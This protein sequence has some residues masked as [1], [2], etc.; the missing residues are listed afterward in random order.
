MDIAKPFLVVVWPD[1]GTCVV[2]TKWLDKSKETVVYPTKTKFPTRLVM[3]L[4]EAQEDWEEC[5][6]E[7]LYSYK[8]FNLARKAAILAAEDKPIDSNIETDYEQP[9]KRQL[10]ARFTQSSDDNN[11]ESENIPTKRKRQAARGFYRE[12]ESV[13]NEE[14]IEK[15]QEV[16]QKYNVPAPPKTIREQLAA[17][18]TQVSHPLKAKI[19]TKNPAN[20][21]NS[22]V[23]DLPHTDLIQCADVNVSKNLFQSPIDE[24]VTSGSEIMQPMTQTSKCFSTQYELELQEK[25]DNIS[26]SNDERSD[27]NMQNFEERRSA[28]YDDRE[29]SVKSDTVKSSLADSDDFSHKKGKRNDGS[30]VIVSQMFENIF[31]V[32]EEMCSKLEHMEVK[33]DRIIKK[34]FPEEIK[35]QRPH[36]IPTFPLRTEED[37]EKQ[38][39]ILADDD[40]LTYVVDVFVTKMKNK[41]SEVA[42]V[43]SVL[44]KIITNS[45]SRAISWGGTQKTKIAFNK[46]KTYDAIQVA[47]L[48][49]FGK[50]RNLKKVEDYVK[51]WF[52]T[53]AQRV[54]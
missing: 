51:R 53:S 37:W 45:L 48:Q 41:E 18:K 15:S 9:R 35:L 4:V 10:P 29:S 33:L 16:C 26:Q 23:I 32:Q 25:Q 12:L 1:G 42:A 7:F 31:K 54:V 21:K 20:I 40:A 38:E 30:T 3:A 39:E 2:A 27:D 17:I 44:P 8:T 28:Q 34:L 49:T 43:Q 47:I 13:E 24:D 52:S 50:T 36:G 46:S 6:I 22:N 19:H 14:H 11:S 5:N